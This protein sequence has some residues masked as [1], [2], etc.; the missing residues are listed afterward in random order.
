MCDVSIKNIIS[1]IFMTHVR[2][3]HYLAKTSLFQIQEISR[4]NLPHSKSIGLAKTF[5]TMKNDCCQVSMTANTLGALRII[6][7]ITVK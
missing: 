6:R 1:K 5:P 7:G 4:L 2:L 3:F